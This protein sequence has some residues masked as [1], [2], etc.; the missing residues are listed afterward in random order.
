[1]T[2]KIFLRRNG[3]I[4]E[5]LRLERSSDASIII[6]PFGSRSP[7]EGA[8]TWDTER[9]QFLPDLN[10][11]NAPRRI[12]Y[13]TSGRVNYH[14][15]VKSAPRFFDPLFDVTRHNHFFLMSIPRVEKLPPLQSLSPTI[16]DAQHTI[17]DVVGPVDGRVTVAFF[18]IPP[19]EWAPATLDLAPYIHIGYDTHAV[20]LAIIEDAPIQIPDALKHHFFYAAPIVGTRTNQYCG[21]SEAE[22]AYVQN[23]F[24]TQQMIV[25]GPDSHGVYSLY[26]C[27][28]MAGAPQLTI[29]FSEANLR[30]EVVDEGSRISR[31]R[32]RI[33]DRGGVITARDL[34]SLIRSIELSVDI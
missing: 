1:M 22:L 26:P 21:K 5:F 32:F 4:Y 31:L 11:S 8:M 13:H 25:D 14:G 27:T 28:I 7:R 3:V 18:V 20:L 19:G 16:I 9:Q 34:R 23:L 15:L 2:V 10:P 24:D 33:C 6:I 29:E 17:L 12:S 30:A